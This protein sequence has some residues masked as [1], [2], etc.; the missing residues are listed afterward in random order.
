M[1]DD[2][3][4]RDLDPT[5][6]TDELRRRAQA[7]A[8]EVLAAPRWRLERV[9]ERC[10]ARDA[11]GRVAYRA[12]FRAWELAGVATVIV[13][14]QGQP[15]EVT[16]PG[17]SLDPAALSPL[18]DLP[19]RPLLLEAALAR[20][21]RALP[22]DPLDV[23]AASWRRVRSAAE[24]VVVI[25]RARPDGE[26]ALDLDARTGE[27]LAC[28][29]RPLLRGTACSA[30]LGRRTAVARARRQAP[31]LPE[32]ARLVRARLVVGRLGRVWRVRWQGP[33]ETLVVTLNARSGALCAWERSSAD[34]GDRT[35]A[36]A[37]AALRL[38][39]DLRVSEAAHVSTPVPGVRSGR[40]VWMAVVHAPGGRLFRAVLEGGRVELVRRGVGAAAG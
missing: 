31:T 40:Q 21:R 25:E 5:L 28:L 4:D 11:G 24:V 16:F 18:P 14:A 10:R 3:P 27:R 1:I 15:V 12:R 32:G 37:A 38:A 34:P 17:E 39:V 23:R 26:L 20:A 29:A 35:R 33:R 22:D 36:D 2:R 8:D 7:W 9:E 30:A 6:S 19:Q 13:G